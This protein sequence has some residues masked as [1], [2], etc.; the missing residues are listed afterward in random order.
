MYVGREDRHIQRK[1]KNAKTFIL[2]VVKIDIYTGNA[3]LQVRI[4][5]YNRSTISQKVG[6]FDRHI[7]R[8]QKNT[9]SID[10]YLGNWSVKIDMYNGKV[11]RWDDIHL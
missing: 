1:S 9:I 3:F 6:H 5:I 11:I 8:K 10:I 2:T 4:D 7:Q